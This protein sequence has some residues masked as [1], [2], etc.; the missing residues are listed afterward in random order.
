M[1]TEVEFIVGEFTRVLDERHRISL[2]GEMVDQLKPKDGQCI[3]AK[4]RTGCLSLWGQAG[5]QEKLDEGVSLVHSKIRAGKLEGK[6]HQVQLLGRLLSTRH[7]EVKL[8]NRKRLLVPDGFREF[9]GVEP[10][11]EV[12]VIGAAVC[13]E[14][15]HP[16]AWLTYLNRR[17][18]RFRQLFDKLSS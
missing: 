10:G 2:P 11:G 14:L 16:E 13:I 18:P 6:L 17:I 8:A 3:L 1:G 4:E 15:W 9:L 5:W 12:L 7:T